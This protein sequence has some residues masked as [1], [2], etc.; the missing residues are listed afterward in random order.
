VNR[1]PR[2]ASNERRRVGSTVDTSGFR[3]PEILWYHGNMPRQSLIAA[4]IVALATSPAFASNS[5]GHKVVAELSNR[6]RFGDVWDS[7]KSETDPRR[8][9]DE[10]HA[11][12]ESFVYDPAILAAVRSTPSGEK[13]AP[14]DLPL[15][16]YKAAGEQ[17][18]KRVLAAGLRLGVLLKTVNQSK[19]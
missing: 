19:N 6:Q 8:W 2:I 1:A 3:R 18:R 12:C 7:A 16:Y 10:S 15:E 13:I 11:L 5:L 4:F 14:I 9:A 17:A